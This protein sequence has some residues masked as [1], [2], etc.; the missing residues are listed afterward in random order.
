MLGQYAHFVLAAYGVTILL[1]GGLVGVSIWRSAKVRAALQK[2]E[3][4]NGKT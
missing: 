1:V 3:R 2:V 4:Q